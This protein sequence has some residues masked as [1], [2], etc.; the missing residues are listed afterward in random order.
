MP[1][2]VLTQSCI[3]TQ[4]NVIFYNYILFFMKICLIICTFRRNDIPLHA[5]RYM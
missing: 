3:C 2:V 4:R 5:E 1:S